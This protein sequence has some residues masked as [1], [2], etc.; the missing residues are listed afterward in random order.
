MSHVAEPISPEFAAST[1]RNLLAPTFGPLQGWKS[2]RGHSWFSNS[3]KLF[4]LEF[5]GRVPSWSFEFALNLYPKYPAHMKAAV[6]SMAS[7]DLE[8]D[9]KRL[10]DAHNLPLSLTGV[11]PGDENQY[12]MAVNSGPAAER[13]AAELAAVLAHALPLLAGID[14]WQALDHWAN[15]VEDADCPFRFL[16]R[17]ATWSPMNHHADLAIARAAGA[18]DFTARAS[19]KLSRYRDRGTP[20]AG[21][22]EAFIAACGQPT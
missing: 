13:A 3:T 8:I 12:T 14:S 16:R 9:L 19:G 5:Y 2:G 10:A 15:R 4:K 1:L 22:L 20:M 11:L 21:F 17:P 6:L 7:F 18:P